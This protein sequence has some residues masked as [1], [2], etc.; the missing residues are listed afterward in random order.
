MLAFVFSP[1]FTILMNFH[2]VND[3]DGVESFGS[4][5][6]PPSSFIQLNTGKKGQTLV[7]TGYINFNRWIVLVE[8]MA[9]SWCIHGGIPTFSGSYRFRHI[10]CG[11]IC[12]EP[13]SSPGN[14]FFRS[15]WTQ[16][17]PTE[18]S[19]LYVILDHNKNHAQ[20][21]PGRNRAKS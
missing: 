3:I 1:L 2:D 6:P 15:V 21:Q 8:C 13:G 18:A 4:S 14:H 7:H 11:G 16:T 19:S 12:W 5:L 20:L 10:F 17:E 9:F